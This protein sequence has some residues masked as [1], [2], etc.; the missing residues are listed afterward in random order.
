MEIRYFLADKK[1][2]SDVTAG[3]TQSSLTKVPKKGDVVNVGKIKMVVRDILPSTMH[4][5]EF[6]KVLLEQLGDSESRLVDLVERLDKPVII[7]LNE[8]V[9]E[10][11]SKTS[12]AKS[13]GTVKMGGIN[14][15][16][17]LQQSNLA[18]IDS[19]GVQF[20]PCTI[21]LGNYMRTAIGNMG[22]GYGAQVADFGDAVSVTITYSNAKTGKCASQS[23]IIIWQP[24]RDPKYPYKVY[25]NISRYRTCAGIDQAA[26]FIRGK[27]SALVGMTSG[28]I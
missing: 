8:L 1:S 12:P 23:F 18:P 5:K 9:N 14:W 24:D 3:M 16:Q 26:N 19:W 20:R 27:A 28:S 10:A 4:G 17:R 25:A 11:K 7:G 22:P 6:T 15:D 13:A 21:E 2:W